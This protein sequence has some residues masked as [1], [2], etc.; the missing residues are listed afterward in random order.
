M[1]VAGEALILRYGAA[2]ESVAKA[3]FLEQFF[4]I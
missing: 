4:R 2:Q 3:S 1:G